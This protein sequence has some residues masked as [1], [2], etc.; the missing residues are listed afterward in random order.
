L[1]SKRTT[2]NATGMQ[3]LFAVHHCGKNSQAELD[4]FTIGQ[5][6]VSRGGPSIERAVTASRCLTD[7]AITFAD[8]NPDWARAR[9]GRCSSVANPTASGTVETCHGI[10]RKAS[11]VAAQPVLETNIRSGLCVTEDTMRRF[12]KLTITRIVLLAIGFS[13]P[14][15]NGLAQG[16]KE[17]VG[18][19]DPG[20][21]YCQPGRTKE[22]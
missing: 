12:R 19:V 11:P 13:L 8:D 16:S 9:H 4:S 7:N 6:S 5:L 14:A 1:R 17:L 22:K 18:G 10:A 15:S 3:A 2:L 20:L 21:D